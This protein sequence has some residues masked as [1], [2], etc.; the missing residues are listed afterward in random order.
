MHAVLNG[1][2]LVLALFGSWA[3]WHY[4]NM[5]SIPNLYSLHSWIG[6]LTLL[7][8]VGQFAAGFLTFLFPGLSLQYRR[9]ILPYH[10][11]MG[12]TLF[13]MAGTTALLGITEKAFFSLYDLFCYLLLKTNFYSNFYSKLY[14]RTQKGNKYADLP[15]A[16]V[17][18]NLLGISILLFVAIVVYLVTNTQFKRR[19]LPEEQALQLQHDETSSLNWSLSPYPTSS[20]PP[21]PVFILIKQFYR[22]FI[23]FY[24]LFIQFSNYFSI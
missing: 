1:S 3:V 24:R 6:S 9:L 22:L 11:Y 7:L 8:F 19:P 5:K 20:F 15:A 10:T 23:Q 16:G 2:A 13:V 18:L 21:K 17:V 4:H 12:L 14:Q